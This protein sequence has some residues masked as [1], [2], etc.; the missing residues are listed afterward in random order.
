MYQ[1]CQNASNRHINLAYYMR[2]HLKEY[3][4]TSTYDACIA[5][6]LWL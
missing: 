2:D 6:T 5:I 4:S 3:G 1:S